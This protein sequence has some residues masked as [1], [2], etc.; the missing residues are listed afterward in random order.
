[1]AACT[2]LGGYVRAGARELRRSGNLLVHWIGKLD[3][4]PRPDGSL[5][6]RC[7]AVVYLAPGD[8]GSKALYVCVME[9]VLVHAEGAWRTA[10]RRV[11]R[12]DLA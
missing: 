7:S 10:H 9:D 12:D 6:T 8:S 3:V 1:V 11:I 2:G 5:H 4:Q